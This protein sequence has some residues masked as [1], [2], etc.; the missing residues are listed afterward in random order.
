MSGSASP[1]TSPWAVLKIA[2]G[3]E[4]HR[5]AMTGPRDFQT[6]EKALRITGDSPRE[7]PAFYLDDEGDECRLVPGSFTD[8]LTTAKPAFED[9]NATGKRP[10]LRIRLRPACRPPGGARST[11]GSESLQDA[12]PKLEGGDR[13]EGSPRGNPSG[14][15]G[16]PWSSAG[17]EAVKGPECYHLV[18]QD[19]GSD[20]DDDEVQVMV[21]SARQAC[22][23]AVIEHLTAWLASGPSPATFEAWLREVHPENVR[24]DKVDRRM[25]L[26]ESFH[27]QLWNEIAVGA[28]DLTSEERECR[29]V[30]A[31][32]DAAPLPDLSPSAPLLSELVPFPPLDGEAAGHDL[33]PSA[34]PL[35]ELERGAGDPQ[36]DPASAAASPSGPAGAASAGAAAEQDGADQTPTGRVWKKAA[37]PYLAHMLP[38][39]AMMIRASRPLVD[40]TQPRLPQEFCEGYRRLG[41]VLAGLGPD[42][43]DVAA[44]ATELAGGDVPHGT[45]VATLT[46]RAAQLSLKNRF[47][48]ANAFC[49][50]CPQASLSCFP[51]FA[52]PVEASSIWRGS[53][54]QVKA[55]CKAAH[56]AHKRA[57]K[58]TRQ[59]LKS[60]VKAAR[61]QYKDALRRAAEERRQAL[62]LAGQG[63]VCARQRACE[64]RLAAQEAATQYRATL[65]QA[66][67]AHRTAIQQAAQAHAQAQRV[68]ARQAEE[69]RRAAA[70]QAAGAHP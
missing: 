16:V 40:L 57:V 61:Q 28:P 10:V 58:V 14:P 17:G 37:V 49:D 9:A 26:E 11:A 52:L 55:A 20:L 24:L 35:P 8:F 12:Q 15:D 31:L 25:Y 42:F 60:E 67:E 47:W 5:V 22:K 44:A 64:A 41:E 29:F 43:C 30:P 36:G 21:E 53:G 32:A 59:E 34:P 33:A 2:C 6:V 51:Q 69:A 56:D 66:V 4:F 27:R 65:Q 23:E 18:D 39:C 54:R 70:D 38:V 7:I 68:L 48:Y 3:D 45:G 63:P 13:A 19:S 1:T 50:C 62:P 46:N